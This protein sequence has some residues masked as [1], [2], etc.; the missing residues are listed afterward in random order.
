MARSSRGA[1]R[2]PKYS[3][4]SRSYKGNPMG[5]KGLN[6]AY[7]SPNMTSPPKMAKVK[8]SAGRGR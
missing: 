8:G 3:T 2:A 1:T 5:R 6:G 4:P 7:G